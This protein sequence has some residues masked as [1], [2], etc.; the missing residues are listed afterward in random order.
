MEKPSTYEIRMLSIEEVATRLGIA[1]QT[2][3]N[4]LGPRA[5]KK[6]PIKPRKVCGSVRFRSDDVD[7]FILSL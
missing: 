1:P 4:K 5:K 7:K 3:R 2:I 6:F